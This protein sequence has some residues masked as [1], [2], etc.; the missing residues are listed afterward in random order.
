QKPWCIYLFLYMVA[1]N[2]HDSREIGYRIGNDDG[3]NI[4][5]IGDSFLSNK[6][7]RFALRNDVAARDSHQLIGIACRQVEDRKGV[8]SGVQT[9]A[10]PISKAMVYLFIPLHGGGQSA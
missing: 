10:L 5:D 4:K 9:C 8:V 6:L 2:R 3:V 1:A 7:M